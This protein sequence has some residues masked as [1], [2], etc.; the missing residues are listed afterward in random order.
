MDHFWEQN[1]FLLLEYIA[2]MRIEFVQKQTFDLFNNKTDIK[3]YTKN[4]LYTVHKT[5]FDR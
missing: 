3:K 1:A 5:I 2:L 4:R